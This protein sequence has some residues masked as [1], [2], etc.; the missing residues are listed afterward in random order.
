[1]ERLLLLLLLLL[2]VLLFSLCSLDP[3]SPVTPSLFWLH[4]VGSHLP[5][6]PGILA[7]ARGNLLSHISSGEVGSRNLEDNL[8]IYLFYFLLLLN[9]A[10]CFL[11]VVF[12]QGLCIY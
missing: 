7:F 1:M 8:Y 4:H 10:Y 2:L 6:M 3:G 11:D 12:T 9:Y 5:P